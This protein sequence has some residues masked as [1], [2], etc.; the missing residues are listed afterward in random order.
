MSEERYGTFDDLLKEACKLVVAD[1]AAAFLAL[2]PV[3]EIDPWTG[4]ELRPGDPENCQGNGKEDP[5]SCCCDGCNFFLAC[6]PEWD[7]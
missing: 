6:F 2:D 1:E 5:M 4:T 3:T 7:K